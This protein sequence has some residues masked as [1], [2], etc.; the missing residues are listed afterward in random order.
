MIESLRLQL[1]L[2]LTI[3]N[4]A[5]Y[6]NFSITFNKFASKRRIPRRILNECIEQIIEE[7]NECKGLL[8]S[9]LFHHPFSNK[10]L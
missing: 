3:P 4:I 1:D 7:I 8:Y 6:Y 2:C 5:N 9:L 10:Y